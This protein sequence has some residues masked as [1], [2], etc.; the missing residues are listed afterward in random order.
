MKNA[1]DIL[2][3]SL[4]TIALGQAEGNIS[5]DM[6]SKAC[7]KFKL[8]T[9][10]DDGYDYQL[11][12]SKSLYDQ[13]NGVEQDEELCKALLP[14][15]TKV[16]DGVM[17]QWSPTKVGSKTQYA[18]H[19]V[20]RGKVTGVDIGSGSKQTPQRIQQLEQFVNEL[21]PADLSSLK[22]I[23]AAGGSTGAQ[24]VE[25][26]KGNRYIMK[27][28]TN[29]HTNND[30]V[31]NEYLANQ[32]YDIAGVRVPN[33]QLYDEAGTAVLLSK[34]ISNASPVS[35][36]DYPELAK[37]F[38][39]D[40]LFANWDAYANSDNCLVDS[41]GQ[42]IHV[43]NGGTLAFRAHG[44][45]KKF[46]GDIY[47]TFISMQSKNPHI[48]STLD[49][50]DILKQITEIRKKKGDLVNYLKE[51]GEDALAKTIGERIDNLKDIV[52]AIDKRKNLGKRT[53]QPRTLMPAKDMYREFTEQELDQ[54]W[55]S[56]SGSGFQK[57]TEK[58]VGPGTG[59]VALSEVCRMR[60]FD[61]RG[62]VID[63]KKYWEEI[64]KSVK[65]G[66][67]VQL[68][69][70]L[71]PDDRLG[72]NKGRI[73][74]DEAV[75]SLLFQDECFYGT[76]GAY[77]AG[78]YAHINDGDKPQDQEESKYKGTKA[79][80][81]A[82]QYAQDGGVG[83][84]AIVKMVMAKDA[85]IAKYEDL[86]KEIK[87][88]APGVDK[89]AID[90]CEKEI[91]AIDKKLLAVDG[92]IQNY[93]VKVIQDAYK[94]AHYDP[95]AWSQYSLEEQA[96]DW[97]K[98]DAFGDRDIPSYDDFVLGKMADL[99]KA[100]GGVVN[101]KR[102]VT[103]FKL[104]NSSE[105]I[106]ISAYQYDGPHSIKRMNSVLPYYN[107]AVERFNDWF[108][109]NQVRYAEEVKE[110]AIKN[111]ADGAKR[112]AEKKE[113][114]QQKR[115]DKERE[116]QTL[117][118]PSSN[119]NADSGIYEAIYDAYTNYY[120]RCVVGLYAALKGYD[121]IKVKNGN[122]RGNSFMVILN[123]SKLS[124]NKNVDMNI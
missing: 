28:G 120:E 68:L 60:G 47:D 59:W 112:L 52:T 111:G 108:D 78:I 43:D 6:L 36:K 94:A 40:C 91:Q 10:F 116:L 45:P 73:T 80:D 83:K 96:V 69:R 105:E 65:A 3:K 17:Y 54:L 95:E 109:R 81:H 18:W 70:G 90:D 23:K 49:D 64:D 11:I 124:I 62:D 75:D 82:V 122:G 71:A 121:G 1:E 22:V 66:E 32:L 89:Q 53:V 7:E 14:G 34:Y 48:A 98:K 4:E 24:I 19:V 35:P 103:V 57:V 74:I 42:I 99:V 97:G 30:H 44:S 119:V 76:Q 41:K 88:L 37:N 85:K 87:D 117:R 5:T 50:D 9:E 27:K 29:V 38:I 21:F 92:E 113:K 77:G 15:E 110:E 51:V 115:D 31:I 46:D 39:A 16:I 106:S 26:V 55:N 104:P 20:Q 63:D 102:G 123:R 61:A 8:L 13:L 114:L 58:K 72:S 67:S 107:Y 33:Y 84:G 56:L 100:N 118:N 25:D 2:L 93:H 86:E 101:V 79:Y 12:V